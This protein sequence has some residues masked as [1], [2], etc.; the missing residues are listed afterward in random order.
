MTRDNNTV[1]MTPDYSSLVNIQ[2]GEAQRN[3]TAEEPCLLSCQQRKS[4]SDGMHDLLQG[5]KH[6]A[7][8]AELG[9]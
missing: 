4:D 7:D 9:G 3:Q 2:S 1:W 5:C 8:K 6:M